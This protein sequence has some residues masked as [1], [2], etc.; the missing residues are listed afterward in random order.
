MSGSANLSLKNS[1][2]VVVRGTGSIGLRHLQVLRELGLTAFAFPSRSN[3]VRE[4]LKNFEVIDSFELVKQRGIGSAIVASNTAAHIV[5]AIQLLEAG[6]HLLVEKPLA[7]TGSGLA[8]LESA[9]NSVDR[10]IFTACCLRFNAGL[11]KFRE[12]LPSLGPIHH[13][14]IECQSYLPDWRPGV[15]HRLNYAARADEGGVLRDLVHEIDYA[16]W[17]YGRPQSVYAQL[18]NSGVLELNAEESAD[19]LWSV[20][21][22]SI[23][24]RLD[25]L[26]RV[27]RRIMRADGD[28]GSLEWNALAGEVIWKSNSGQV[29]LHNFPAERNAIY[30]EQAAAFIRTIATGEHSEFLAT[31]DDGAFAV[32]V[33]D[34]ARR[35]SASGKAESIDDWRRAKR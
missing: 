28:K 1:P 19:L 24:I 5:D 9:A 12:L 26:S 15:D 31:M 21:K 3:Q 20:G 7:A 30:R 11:Q 25:Y 6:C 2:S 18:H 8:E 27:S 14:R 32:A 22:T 13:V 10:K 17:L 4:E 34:A 35:S 33:C 29:E 16:I 23:S